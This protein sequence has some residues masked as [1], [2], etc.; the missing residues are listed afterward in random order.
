MF[1]KKE[2]YILE[3]IDRLFEIL[4]QKGLKQIDICKKLNIKSNIVTT[5]KTR[6]TDP[7]AKYIAQIC[8]LL[9]IST[10]YLLTGN[11][12][13]EN[14]QSSENL[15]IKEKELLRS[16]RKLPEHEQYINNAFCSILY[17]DA[18]IHIFF[19]NI[20]WQRLHCKPLKIFFKERKNFLTLRAMGLTI[21][22]FDDTPTIPRGAA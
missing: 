11:E 15:T 21:Q 20:L 1:T 7:P 14:E 8:E 13:K 12:Q 9:N 3:I 17:F 10:D 4:Q 19:V 2:V 18:S 16:F 6:K 5:W 22:I